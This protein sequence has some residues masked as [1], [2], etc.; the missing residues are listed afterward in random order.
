MPNSSRPALSVVVPV[1]NVAG[2]L[3]E[4]IDSIRSQHV[5]GVEIV[6]VDDGSTDE[7]PAILA[8]LATREP[9]LRI[10]TQ[11]NQGLGAARNTGIDHASGE[12]LWFVDSDDRLA[13]GAI[14]MMLATIRT[15]GSDLVTGNV[16]R[17]IGDQQSP[18]R[19]L[20]ETFERTRPR[21]N[22]RRFPLLIND[23]VAWNKVYRRSFWDQHNFRFPT[24]VHY[25][26]QYVTLP[27]HYLAHHV[28]VRREPVYLWRVRDESDAASITQQRTDPR[29]MQD[30]VQAVA[31]VSR[32]LAERGRRRDKLRYDESAVTHDLRY[33][34]DVFD[35]ADQTYRD[36]FVAAV[37]GYLGQVDERAFSRLPAIRRL[38]WDLVRTGD[39]ERAAELV[40]FEHHD[41]ANASATRSGRRWHAN[42][43]GRGEPGL[44]E[45]RYV[46]RRELRLTSTVNS[47]EID[48]TTIRVRGHAAI[49]LVGDV[50]RGLRMLAVPQG[51]ARPL[52]VA[53]SST[54]DG[55]Y[56]AEIPLT[57]IARTSRGQAREW[58]LVLLARDRGLR[59]VAAWH[60]QSAA[61]RAAER[62]V[63]AAGGNVE[64]RL[65]ITGRGRLTVTTSNPVEVQRATVDGDV[66]E[67]AGQTRDRLAATQVTVA[68]LPATDPLPVHVEPAGSGS[69]FLARIPL[70][71]LVSTTTAQRCVEVI[72][73]GGRRGLGYQGSDLTV[74]VGGIT[75]RIGRDDNGYLAVSPT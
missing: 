36:A 15:T 73:T 20:A 67:L 54:G 27:A 22:I 49:D 8:D 40:R 74:T 61:T 62:I 3:A 55:S 19:F 43:P 71:P 29:S 52:P 30:R 47:L 11:D 16:V 2:Y 69:A 50:A 35:T 21:T 44:P 5:D 41:L 4:C 18:T 48:A 32:F 46:V 17:L 38:Q 39:T 31:Y 12:F 64:A 60:E 63:A 24:G 33:F 13:P 75:L 10:V 57:R 70:V 28:D 68:G 45:N 23:R 66:L 14:T 51:R 59:R 58:R 53:V 9:G 26:D 25:E 37:T 42:Y 72:G 56:V 34:L 6:A 65:T 7:S 1:Y